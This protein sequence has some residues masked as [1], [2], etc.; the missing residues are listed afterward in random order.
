MVFTEEYKTFI[1]NFYVIKPYK[2]QIL[3]T[4]FP[5]KGWNGQIGGL[6]KFLR[7]LHKREMSKHK[8][9]SG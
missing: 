5:A 3:M 7:E 8:R 1:R 2:P 4:E 6:D 9:V